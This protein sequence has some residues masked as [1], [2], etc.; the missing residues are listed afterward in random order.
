[1]KKKRAVKLMT[2]LLAASLVFGTASAEGMWGV[3]SASA[4]NDPVTPAE[5]DAAVTAEVHEPMTWEVPVPMTEEAPPEADVEIVSVTANGVTTN[6]KD[7]DAA[8][9]AAQNANTAEITL[10]SDIEI[11]TGTGYIIDSGDDF[12]ING[13][14]HSLTYRSSDSWSGNMFNV[15]NGGKLTINSGKFAAAKAN[16]R[17]ICVG[18]TGSLTIN[19]GEFSSN[20]VTLLLYDNGNS[21]LYG[22]KFSG[23]WAIRL[24]GFVGDDRRL[25]RVLGNYGDDTTDEHY[26]I[27]AVGGDYYSGDKLVDYK[28]STGE[29]VEIVRCDHSGAP[30]HGEKCPY[31]CYNAEPHTFGDDGVCTAAGCGLSAEASVTLL[32]T[33]TFYPS[34]FDALDTALNGKPVN[35]EY[36]IYSINLLRDISISEPIVIDYDSNTDNGSKGIILKSEN[37]STITSSDRC[38]I[39]VRNGELTIESGNYIATR[40]ANPDEEY[41]DD[42]GAL[43]MTHDFPYVVIKGGVFEG[44]DYGFY[45]SNGR[46]WLEG[47][48]FKG[49]INSIYTERYALKE[50]LFN[51]G[52]EDKTF[53]FYGDSGVIT[54]LG[55]ATSITGTVTVKVCTHD[56]NDIAN[57]GLTHGGRN[58][59]QIDTK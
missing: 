9:Q 33:T 46:F 40:G 14:E 12:T 1:M 43:S 15:Y 3:V 16:Y 7:F 50:Y 11:T 22:G 8:W 49:G 6:Y 39:D 5:P 37:N 23:N 10:L 17:T 20:Y 52:Y 19:G 28:T 41:D 59:P 2:C 4:G 35:H 58:H 34:F 51:D 54:D 44:V 36:W 18:E 30:V 45:N 21:R 24:S 57:N 42:K 13:G 29:A 38:V 47:G 53:A 25:C 55:E 27:K 26:A 32:G 31:C 48:T 56:V